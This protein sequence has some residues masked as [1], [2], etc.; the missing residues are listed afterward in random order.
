MA[1]LV[2]NSVTFPNPTEYTC[3]TFDIVEASRNANGR[4]VADRVAV[5]QKIEMSWLFLTQ[6]QMTT[7]LNALASF[8]FS[9]TFYNP[10]SATNLTKTFYTGDRSAAIFNMKDGIIQGYK[11]FTLALIEV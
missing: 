3:S 10:A 2:V 1:L 4:L 11:G 5:K 9:V 8:Q 6:A 7:I